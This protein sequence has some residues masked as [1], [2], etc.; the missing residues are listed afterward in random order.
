MPEERGVSTRNA[1]DLPEGFKTTELGPLPEEWR[2]VRLGEVAVLTMGQSPPSSTYNTVG[3]GLP[4]LQGKAEFRAV[5]PAPI[6]WCSQPQRI[7]ER[8]SVLIS[9][10]APVG[11][12]NIADRVYCI[13]RGL[14]AIKGVDN[15]DNWFLFYQL[16]FSKQRLEEK[17]TGSTFKSINKGV[18]QNLP[19]PLPPLPEQR[20]IAYVLRAVQR[21]KEATERVL[22]ALKELK[23][24]LMKHLFTYGPVPLDQADQVPLKKTEIGPV[25]ENWELVKLGELCRIVR[26]GSPRPKGDPRYFSKRPTGIH[27]IKISDLTK[28]K[29]GLYITATDEYLTEEGKRKSRFLRRGTFVVT[30]SGTVGIPAFLGIDGCIHDGYL[31]FLDIETSRLHGFYL[32]Y[33]IENIKTYLE[34]IAP[35]GTQANLNT[36]IAKN[37]SI[38]LPPIPEQRAIAR[39]LQT[40]D[41]KIEAE[42]ARKEALEGL[43]KTLLHHLMMAKIRLPKEFIRR[44]EETGSHG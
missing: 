27:W 5:Y 10:R 24:S 17:G 2:V 7:A 20:A 9:V 21:A 19:I 44:F 26:G 1:P 31:A 15:L 22:T 33:W 3:Q 34:K 23:K 29:R 40:V 6:K 13:G 4:F 41:R 37:L 18:L 39:I 25:P 8:G 28:Y 43:F 11:N 36:T 14:A 16:I 38:S 35:R 12:V 42:E 30:N 32:Y